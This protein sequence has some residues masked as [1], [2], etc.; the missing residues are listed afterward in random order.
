MH[1]TAF[2]ALCASG[3]LWRHRLAVTEHGVRELVAGLD[4]AGLQVVLDG[5]HLVLRPEDWRQLRVLEA[6]AV[7]AMNGDPA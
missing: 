7:A 4:Y 3:T 5:L 1:A 2:V 6:A